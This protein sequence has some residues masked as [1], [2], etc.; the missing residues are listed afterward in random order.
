MSQINILRVAPVAPGSAPVEVRPGPAAV[1]L[2]SLL[3][4]S[5]RSQE[6][7]MG[8]SFLKQL[9]LFFPFIL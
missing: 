7:E 3:K 6:V 4:V 9:N 8:S 2:H 5:L 1:S